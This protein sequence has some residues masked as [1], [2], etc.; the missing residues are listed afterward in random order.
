MA[1]SCLSGPG[2]L[3]RLLPGRLSRVAVCGAEARLRLSGGRAPWVQ[4]PTR[5]AGDRAGPAG[6]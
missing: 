2:R 6:G 3:G 5:A 4:V 1:V